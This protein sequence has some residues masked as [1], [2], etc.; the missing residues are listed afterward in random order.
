MP[1]ISFID[2]FRCQGLMAKGL[3]TFWSEREREREP[4]SHVG[5]KI[6]L[7]WLFISISP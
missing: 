3:I 4:T 7:R 1:K 2:L 6:E 5:S